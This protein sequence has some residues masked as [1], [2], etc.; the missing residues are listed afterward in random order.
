M[1]QIYLAKFQLTNRYETWL[2]EGLIDNL[3]IESYYK[4]VTYRES[5]SLSVKSDSA[6]LWTIQST[7]FSRPEY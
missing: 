3:Q 5:E 7:E 1:L 4:M 2:F 6:T